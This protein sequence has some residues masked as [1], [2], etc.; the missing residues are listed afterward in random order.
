MVRLDV[1]LHREDC[2]YREMCTPIMHTSD[3]LDELTEIYEGT[4]CY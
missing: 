2:I 3:V 1:L 4:G